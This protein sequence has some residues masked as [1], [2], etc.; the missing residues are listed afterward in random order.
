M[1][2]NAIVIPLIR[3]ELCHLKTWMRYCP[4]S[5]E[6][7]KTVYLS[8]D[9]TWT[10]GEKTDIADTF[11]R[12]ALHAEDWRLEFIECRMTAEESFYEKDASAFIDLEKHPYGQKSGPNMQF[13]RTIRTLEH[14]RAEIGAVLLMEVDAFPVGHHWLSKLNHSLAK[15]PD[16][17]LV[18]GP[19]YSG[20]APL[21]EQIQEHLNGNSVYCIGC[22]DFYNFLDCWEALL[23]KA[24][25][26]TPFM[27][28]DVV[29]PWYFNYKTTHPRVLALTSEEATFAS[30]CFKNRTLDL[31]E[32]LINYGGETENHSAFRLNISS[33]VREF[34]QALI[35]HGKCFNDNI[36][37]LRAAKKHTTRTHPANILADLMLAGEYEEAVL[38]GMKDYEVMRLVTRR[39][40][41]LTP[42]Q[43]C[44]IKR[45]WTNEYHK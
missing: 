1:K 30:E 20:Q 3:G 41:Q 6:N 34:P 22:S 24:L 10:E 45:E 16:D 26:V 43:I 36:H 21:K 4:T 31:T 35:V 29:I 28:Y 15:A 23:L 8:I 25:K 32:M 11:S 14:E 13:Y 12:C 19:R 27:A 42:Q 40:G 5:G 37:A 33:F 9:L 2:V 39:V 17:L 38:L 18:S 44:L 7:G